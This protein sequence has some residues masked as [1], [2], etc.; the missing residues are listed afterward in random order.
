[1]VTVVTVRVTMIMRLMGV[2]VMAM[3]EDAAVFVRQ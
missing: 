1:M 2:T 3:V